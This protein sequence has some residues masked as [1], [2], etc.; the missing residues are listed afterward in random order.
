MLVIKKITKHNIYTDPEADGL[1]VIPSSA[2]CVQLSGDSLNSAI[3][4]EYRALLRPSS[5]C[6]PRYPLLEV[7]VKKMLRLGGKGWFIIILQNKEKKESVIRQLLTTEK[8]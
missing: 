4:T 1:L 6:K 8:A 3:R 7:L 2:I 5:L